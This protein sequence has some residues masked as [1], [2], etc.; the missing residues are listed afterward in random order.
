MH[1]NISSL[2]YQYL[3]LYNLIRDMNIEPKTTGISESRL[4]KAG[5]T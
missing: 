4:Q 3:E 2:F 1:L 5:S